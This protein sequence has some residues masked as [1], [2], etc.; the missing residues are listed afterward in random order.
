MSATYIERLTDFVLGCTCAEIPA[1][2]R[3][4]SAWLLLDALGVAIANRSRPFVRLQANVVSR[5]LRE[6]PCTVIGDT[7]TYVAEGAAQ[8]N[9]TAIHG[10][11]FDATHLPSIM[12]TSSVVVP[13]ALAVAEEVGASGAELIGALVAGSEVLIRMGLATKGAMHRVGFQST[14]LCAPVALALVAGRLYR[15]NREQ[16]VSAAGL[17]ASI[18]AGLRAF[19]DDGTWGKRVI[20]GWACRAGLTATALARE[21]YPGTRDA[22]EKEPFG[23]YKAFVQSGGYDLGELTRALGEEWTTREVDLKRY[24]CSHGHH[25]FLDTARRAKRE[26]ALDPGNIESVVL[27]VSREARKWW[28]EPRHRKYELENTYGARFSLPYTVALVLA[29]GN[30]YDDHLDDRAVLERD[31]VRRLV[32]RVTPTIDPTLSDSNPNRLPGTLEVKTVDGR[33]RT[34]PGAGHVESGAAFKDAVLEKY[35]ANTAGMAPDASRR[36]IELTSTLER[37]ASVAPLMRVL[38]F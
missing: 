3:E 5:T 15:L 23:F 14:A 9:S 25:A 20:T 35:A 8:L 30:L 17:A 7:R 22:L 2:V 24:P 32:S 33:V 21:G 19:S 11:D 27:H 29:F 28:F 13:T 16:I 18:G 10:S 34:F 36:V 6:G 38:R 26:L 31:D 37:Q 4:K 12:H 1:D